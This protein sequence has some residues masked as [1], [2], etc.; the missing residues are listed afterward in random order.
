[1]SMAIVVSFDSTPH[2]FYVLNSRFFFFVSFV[3]CLFLVC[4][5]LI[6]PWPGDVDFVEFTSQFGVFGN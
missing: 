1:M 6:P 2:L 4:V 3:V 5:L